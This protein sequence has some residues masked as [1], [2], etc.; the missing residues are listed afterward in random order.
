MR[1]DEVQRRFEEGT[2]ND[3]PGACEDIERRLV[4]RHRGSRSQSLPSSVDQE[5]RDTL[6]A[7]LARLRRPGPGGLLGRRADRDGDHRGDDPAGD[8]DHAAR[9]RDRPRRRPR[10]RRP[11]PRRSSRRRPSRTP[12]S[13]GGRH[14]RCRRTTTD[15]HALRGRR[16]LPHRPPPRRGRDVHRVPGHRLRARAR[17]RDQAARRAPRR[18]RGLRG[19]LPAR[20]AGRARSSS[21]PTSCRCSTPARTRARTA[22][23]SSWSTWTARPARTCCATRS[24]STW[25][26]PC[27]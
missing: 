3:N 10:P 27:T 20:G 26:R 17:G 21:T 19:A 8:R 15:V 2:E 1:L 25:T 5:V 4:P 23:T 12:A 13:G 16:P 18:G 24:C 22:T 7:G 9:D 14:R 11:R 6:V